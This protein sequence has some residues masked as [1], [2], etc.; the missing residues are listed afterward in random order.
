MTPTRQNSLR[1]LQCGG[2]SKK[3]NYSVVAFH[4]SRAACF[5]RQN[6]EYILFGIFTMIWEKVATANTQ[7]R[8]LTLLLLLL[9]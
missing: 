3:F 6:T 5:V 4:S 9:V 8:F 2:I 7:V 1:Q